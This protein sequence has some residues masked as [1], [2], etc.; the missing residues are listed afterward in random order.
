MPM[1]TRISYW[2]VR[3]AVDH[4]RCQSLRHYKVQEFAS[5]RCICST[6]RGH[7]YVASKLEHKSW[8]T[9]AAFKSRK[10]RH[11]GFLQPPQARRYHQTPIYSSPDRHYRGGEE[12]HPRPRCWW[13]KQSSVCWADLVGR[14]LLQYLLHWGEKLVLCMASSWLIFFSPPRTTEHSRQLSANSLMKS[15]L[16]MPRCV[17]NPWKNYCSYN[18]GYRLARKTGNHPARASSRLWRKCSPVT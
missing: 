18:F 2:R 10:G 14:W 12:H 17:F 7:W 9:D 4:H 3:A 11:R 6:R 1:S 15:S 13:T 5:W 8:S 16:P